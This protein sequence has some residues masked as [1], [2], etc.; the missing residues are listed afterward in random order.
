M[1]N[2]RVLVAAWLALGLATLV[3]LWVTDDAACSGTEQPRHC[4]D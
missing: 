3:G 2:R 4:V 1:R